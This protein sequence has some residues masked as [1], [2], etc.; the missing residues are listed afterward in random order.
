MLMANRALL[1]LTLLS[2]FV[3]PQSKSYKAVRISNPPVIDGSLSDSIW[4]TAPSITDFLQQE[5]QPGTRPSEKTE[6]K[7]LYDES[8]IYVGVFCYDSE[9]G[10]IVAREL[11][12]DGRMSADD[13]FQLLFDT[14]N[15]DKNAYWFATNPLGMHDDALTSGADFSYFNESWNGLWDVRSAITDSGWCAEFIFPL[16]NFKFEGKAPLMWGVNFTREVRRTGEVINWASIGANRGFWHIPFAGDLVF[17][18]GLIR[19]NPVFIKPYFSAGAEKS[20]AE[21]KKIVKGG[22]DIKYPVTRNL[23]LDVSFNSDFAQVEADKAEINLTRFPLFFPEKR[24]FFLEGANVFTFALGGSNRLFYS[25]RIGL[26][27]GKKIPIINGMKLVGRVDNT[28]LG[29]LNVVTN[30]SGNEPL[31]NYSVV[32]AKQDF[33]ENSY[34]GFLVTNKFSSAGFNSVYAG[35]MELAFKRFL[36]EY[37]LI[38]GTGAAYSNSKKNSPESW[39][40]KIYVDFPN[41]LIDFYSG[42]RFIQNDFNPEMGFISRR[43]IQSISNNFRITPRLNKFGIKKLIFSPLEST[44][45]LDDKGKMISGNFTVKPF[46]FNTPQGDE[47]GIEI[48]RTFDIVRSDFS[49][50]KDN[51]IAAGEYLFTNYSAEYQVGKGADLIGGIGITGGNYYDYNVKGYAAE[52][53]FNPNSLFTLESQVENLYFSKG[54]EKFSTL[55]FSTAARFDF[56]TRLFTLFQAQWKNEESRVGL[57]Y[58]INYQPKIGSNVYLVVNHNLETSCKLRT[59]DITVLG[60]IAWLFNL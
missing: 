21:E 1:I 41:D 11:K 7:I 22:L 60:K 48:E 17:E 59:A 56:S 28:E 39:A 36:G 57:I 54:P 58:R 52:I 53:Y 8:N 31:T 6:V 50:F 43:G 15:D 20:E 2:L 13:N 16:Y 5:P 23:T 9:P 37:N 19:G 40:G 29:I 47:F 12:W 33:L 55:E 32:R 34:Y 30:S 27:A 10:K 49:F 45:E 18:D 24:D 26:K 51:I 14:F 38:I 4:Q 44:I 42:Y 25:R 3:F 46:G 35:D